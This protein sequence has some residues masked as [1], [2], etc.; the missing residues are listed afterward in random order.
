VVQRDANDLLRSG[1]Q[2]IRRV[3][4]ERAWDEIGRYD[5]TTTYVSDLARVLN[6]DAIHGSGLKLGVD[7]LGGA[8]VGYWA[9][10]RDRYGLDLTVTNEVV[11]PQFGFMTVDWD[12][13]IRM[14]PSSPYAMAGWWR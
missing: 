13:R 3:H 7:P 10:I 14:D 5:F 2:S 12:G 4:F 9:V 1:V 11:D 6:M 8:S